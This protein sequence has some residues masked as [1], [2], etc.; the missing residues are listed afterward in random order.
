M[1]ESWNK[2]IKSDQFIKIKVDPP[3][4]LK[5]GYIK[6]GSINPF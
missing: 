5:E 2:T 6:V 3:M 1:S 4:P